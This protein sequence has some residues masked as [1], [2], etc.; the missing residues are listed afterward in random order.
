MS[1]RCRC[2]ETER[3]APLLPRSR[4]SV[5]GALPLPDGVVGALSLSG[6]AGVPRGRRLFAVGTA[7]W[8]PCRCS[9][10]RGYR[11]VGALLRSGQRGG[12]LVAVRLG[13]GT[14][15]WAPCRCWWRRAAR[16]AGW[17]PLALATRCKPCPSGRSCP[18]GPSPYR[19]PSRAG[20]PAPHRLAPTGYSRAAATRLARWCCGPGR[21]SPRE[22]AHDGAT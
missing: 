18:H 19:P 21:R 1:R 8:A 7:W 2:R 12:R 11:V 15:W 9:G 17:P 3:A 13:G 5:A 16:G 22:P 14:A 10:R 6:I 4:T 20:R